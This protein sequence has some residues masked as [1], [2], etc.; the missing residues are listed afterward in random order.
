MHSTTQASTPA[1]PTDQAPITWPRSINHVGLTVPDLEMAIDWYS[2][3]LGSR[4]VKSPAVMEARVGHIGEIAADLFGPEFG[5]VR[6]AWLSASNGTAL[7]LFSF[8]KPAYEAPDNSYAYW[9]GGFNHICV[10]DPDIEG[11]AQAIEANGGKRQS[12][13]WTFFDGK[14]YRVCYCLDPFGFLIEIMTHDVAQ[15]FANQD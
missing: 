1:R 10:T 7:E 13:I 4:L 6:A 14:P 9:R 15:I 8:V 11:L 3:V 12:K 2:K 5:K